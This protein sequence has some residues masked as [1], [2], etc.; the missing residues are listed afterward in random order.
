[1]KLRR[2]QYYKLPYK[3]EEVLVKVLD[4]RGWSPKCELVDRLDYIA[5]RDEY[6]QA[7]RYYK[8]EAFVD[9]ERVYKRDLDLARLA[10]V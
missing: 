5:W 4:A 1:M 9:A 8:R 10:V 3:G 6:K 2:G 7:V